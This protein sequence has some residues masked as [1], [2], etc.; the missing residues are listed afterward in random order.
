MEGKIFLSY[1]RDDAAGYALALYHILC[2]HFERDQIF[3]DVDT[4]EPGEDFVQRIEDAVGSCQVVIAI[5]GRRWLSSSDESGRRIDNPY[6]WV[7]LEVS[8]A[9]GSG[10]RVIPLLVDGAT[11][12]RGDELPQALADLARRQAIEIR[13]SRFSSDANHF[14][15]KLKKLIGGNELRSFRQTHQDGEVAELT[16]WR[17]RGL[18]ADENSE[19]QTGGF[20]TVPESSPILGLSGWSSLIEKS[21]VVEKGERVVGELLLYLTD[22]QSTWLV[23]TT[24]QLFCVLDDEATRAIGNLIQW[25]M[26][27]A[28]ASHVMTWSSRDKTFVNIGRRHG[29]LYSSDL[30]PEEKIL[31]AEIVK[32]MD[33]A[34]DEHTP[35]QLENTWRKD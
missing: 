3:M 17:Q 28:E 22:N 9:L 21:Q 13:H 10:I 5:I 2:E 18:E 6:D 14:I 11:M 4:L 29:W 8:A 34:K 26:P 15:T 16:D 24:R 23:A 35:V 32:L 12:P 27:L 1:R 31:V 25:R 19:A 30:W 33:K 7:R 20:F